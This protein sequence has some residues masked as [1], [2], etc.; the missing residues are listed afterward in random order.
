MG[1]ILP[2]LNAV[3]WVLPEPTVRWNVTSQWHAVARVN[4]VSICYLQYTCRWLRGKTQVHRDTD[5]LDWTWFHQRVPDTT[6]VPSRRTLVPASRHWSSPARRCRSSHTALQQYAHNATHDCLRPRENKFWNKIALA[7]H[8]RMR[9][10]PCEAKKL[11]RFIFAIASSELHLLRQFL[12]YIYVN[13]FPIIR[14]FHNFSLYNQRWRTSL[15]FK[16]TAN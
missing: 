10:L 6:V 3:S 12:A 5:W 4:A 14:V 13:K 1:S 7:D 11:H 15:S 8:P 9:A 2:P 16:S